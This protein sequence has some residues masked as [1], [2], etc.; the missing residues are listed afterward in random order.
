MGRLREQGSSFIKSDKFIPTLLRAGAASQVASWVDLF[1][2]F[3][4]FAWAGF[5]PVFATAVGAIVGGVINCVINFH[6]TF[7]AQE[8]SWKAVIVKYFMVWIGSIMLNS[9]GTMGLYN[10]L[11]SWDWL[12]SI[13]FKPDGYYSAARLSVSI[14]VSLFWNLLLQARFV[15]R[16]TRFDPYA[17]RIMDALNIRNLSHK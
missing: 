8:C 6:F 16:V 15:Y 12:E 5:A 7:H 4:L 3:A 10:L 1:T 2:G 11:Q 13:G 9:F 14:I 17:I